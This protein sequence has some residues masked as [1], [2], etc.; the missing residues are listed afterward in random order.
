MNTSIKRY[1]RFA[2]AARAARFAR[3]AVFVCCAAILSQLLLA[4]CADTAAEAPQ[5][6]APDAAAQALTPVS[7]TAA[8][9]PTRALAAATQSTQI[10]DGQRV[11]VWIDE[12]QKPQSDPDT[13]AAANHVAD[14]ACAWR[15]TAKGDGTFYPHDDSD[16]DRAH[17]VMYYPASGQPIDIYALHGNFSY[18]DAHDQ[19]TLTEGRREAVTAQAGGMPTDGLPADV[20]RPANATTW[21]LFTNG[22]RHTVAQNQTGRNLTTEHAVGSELTDGRSGARATHAAATDGYELSDLLYA[23]AYNKPRRTEAHQLTFTHLLSK[24]VVYLIPGEGMSADR[25][26]QSSIPTGYH[27]REGK[28]EWAATV[29]L[30]NTRLAAD[31]TLRKGKAADNKALDTDPA[32]DF[33]TVSPVGDTEDMIYC[34]MQYDAAGTTVAV[35]TDPADPTATVN[36]LA[37]AMAE[38]VIVPQTVSTD[39]SATGT[40]VDLIRISLPSG[41]EFYVKSDPTLNY[42][43][44]HRYVY[45][46]TLNATGLTV[47]TTIMDWTDASETEFPTDQRQPDADLLPD[48]VVGDLYFSDGTWGSRADYPAKTPV[49]IVFSTNTSAKD[50]ALGYKHGYVMALRNVV[51]ADRYWAKSTT[52]AYTTQMTDALVAGNIADVKADLDGLTHCRTALSRATTVTDLNAI[53]AANQ[54]S[55]TPPTFCSEWYLPSIG[56]LYLLWVNLAGYSA[57]MKWSAQSQYWRVSNSSA[58]PTGSDAANCITLMN[59]FLKDHGLTTDEFDAFFNN[60]SSSEND[61]FWSSTENSATSAYFFYHETYKGLGYCFGKALG[62]PA[63]PLK[64][65]PVLAF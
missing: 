37:Y 34:H 49:G 47:A 16:A 57:D 23:R 27:V 2:R 41:G 39:G 51:P 65:R 63:R 19:T 17:S 36:K 5:A 48:P 50:K 9:S 42:Q 52:T 25:I 21:D 61:G 26:Y 64:V 58:D 30:M 18:G 59:Q 29:E 55:V 44:S 38:A 32:T 33:Y 11:Y 54:Y 7:L 40:A 22:L 24:I 62:S 20:L 3:A 53:Y 15:L 43:T 13:H 8:A 6:P 60:S 1:H 31:L 12:H 14:R 56:Q 4:S 35:P 10:A 46:V 45:Y 28:T